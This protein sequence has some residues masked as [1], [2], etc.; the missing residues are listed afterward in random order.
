MGKFSPYSKPMSELAYSL[1][2]QIHKDHDGK[3]TCVV[4]EL[5]DKGWTEEVLGELMI[6]NHAVLYRDKSHRF[7]I[8]IHSREISVYARGLI[9]R[10]AS[11]C[12]ETITRP[13]KRTR[14]RKKTRVYLMRDTS[15]LAIKI[16][17][18]QDPKVRERTLQS[19]KPTVELICHWSGTVADER[20]LHKK[21][22]HKKVRGEWYGLSALDIMQIVEL[23]SDKDMVDCRQDQPPPD[24]VFG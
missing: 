3:L 4:S 14:Q 10:T 12:L 24:E 9:G 22:R 1:L 20:F 21:F 19:E 7:V 17:H 8:T 2:K 13:K 16:G 23:Y 11:E 5:I 6:N 15:S 18:S